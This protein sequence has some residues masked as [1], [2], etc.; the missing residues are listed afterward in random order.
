MLV[1]CRGVFWRETDHISFLPII[2]ISS[3]RAQFFLSA[4][5]KEGIFQKPCKLFTDCMHSSS[6]SFFRLA[7]VLFMLFVY[8]WKCNAKFYSGKVNGMCFYG[9][10]RKLLSY[11]T[12][13]SLFMSV[14]IWCKDRLPL[15]T[16][17]FE[18]LPMPCFIYREKQ[19]LATVHASTSEHTK[20]NITFITLRMTCLLTPIKWF[21]C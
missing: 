12:W 16:T 3:W 6:S 10:A 18:P 8:V 5:I 7:D 13:N 20:Q 21:D 15:H 4:P 11:K 14:Y 19:S 1:V 17:A 9:N 2:K